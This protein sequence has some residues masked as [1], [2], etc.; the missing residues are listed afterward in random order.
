MAVSTR[1]FQLGEVKV[2]PDQSRL[3]IGTEER[4]IEPKVMAVLQQL[5]KRPEQVVS[6]TELLELVWTGTVVTDEVVTRCISELRT[7]LGDDT[8]NPIF[9]QT[10]P[11][12]GYKLLVPPIG[13]GNQ[14]PGIQSASD[15]SRRSLWLTA[16]AL[17]LVAFG[18]LLGRAW[19]ATP[20][21]S[22][23]AVAAA[24]PLALTSSDPAIAI[25]P[26]ATLAPEGERNANTKIDYFGAGLAEELVNA[27]VNVPGLRVASRSAAAQADQNSD[28]TDIAQS[29]GV[30][31]VLT[32]T[33]RRFDD[34]VRVSAQLVN[35][36][37]GFN[38]WAEQFE[39]SFSDVFS[40]QDDIAAAIVDALRLQLT[41]PVRVARISTD[42]AAIEYYLLGRH[43]WHQ[44]TATSLQR[45]VELFELA[46]QADP[47]MAIAHS[48]LADAYL[49][50][51]D[52]GDMDVSESKRLAKPAIEKALAL[53]PGLGE[54]HASLGILHM[55]EG[56][57]AQAETAL[58]EAVR[59]NPGYH[60]AHMWLGGAIAQ[61]G[62]VREAHKYYLKAYQLDPLHGVINQNIAMSFA[63]LGDYTKSLR[64]ID[65]FH[66]R[67]ESKLRVSF[68]ELTLALQMADFAKVQAISERYLTSNEPHQHVHAYQALALMNL[69]NAQYDQASRYLDL[70]LAE[71]DLDYEFIINMALYYVSVG[72]QPNFETL[73]AS[74]PTALQQKLDSLIQALRGILD[75]HQERY[76]D[77]AKKLELALPEG[78]RH[79]QPANDLLLISHLLLAYR[80]M[81]NDDRY[82]YWRQRGHE[83]AAAASR[84]GVGNFQFLV[85]RGFFLATA[86]E[87]N[88]A[89]GLF[90][91]ALQIGKIAPW[92]LTD[93]VRMQN[94]IEH[95]GLKVIL[96]E[97]A[98][99]W[100]S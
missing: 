9:I 88:E 10:I 99:S 1:D 57:P 34:R 75:L 97:A 73:V 39:G 22:E 37:D 70:A 5:A 90:W 20:S 78:E 74:S 77:G 53:E 24:E 29:L 67:G 95:D 93:D 89:A 14:G 6:R 7:A 71:G 19:L 54:A 49:L 48:G 46:V 35:G 26:F 60:M 58:R 40:I 44:R 61:Q 87:A 81:D 80:A 32:G 59:V 2:Y 55:S 27:L 68:L 31:V 18:L 65:R 83:I 76:A 85:Q 38:L 94:I 51:A 4:H 63:A 96:Q 36:S 92:E 13:L 33:L 21:Q 8:K 100:P 41:E 15:K 43:H 86:G 30:D 79:A 52:Y 23:D 66:E 84:A 69:R 50:L 45:A 28:I 47:N 3:E 11:K 16:A 91:Q 12:K 17:G 56:D 62:R 64:V 72:D 42:M 98:R 82:A 25:L